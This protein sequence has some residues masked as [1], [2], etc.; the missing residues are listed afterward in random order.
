MCSSSEDYAEFLEK[1]KSLAKNESEFDKKRHI[2]ILNT[3]QY[4]YGL[5]MAD[6]RNLAKEILKTDYMSFLKI[7]KNDSYEETLIQGLVIAGIKDLGLQQ[8]LL[9]EWIKNID[10]WSTCDSVVSTLKSLKKS[11]EKTKYFEGYKNLCFSSDEFVSR[12]GIITL[13]L[14]YLEVEFIDEILKMCELVTNDKYYVQMGLAWLLS[15]AF[16]KFKD[17]TYML[18]N[19]KCLPKFVQ[20]KAISKCRDSYRVSAEDKQKLKSLRI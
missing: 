6:I 4:V 17:K 19:K 15:F 7:A 3:K 8:K 2:A 5:A 18:L 13:M 10:N 14:C 20:N 9:T 11:K 12:F 16:M 1:L